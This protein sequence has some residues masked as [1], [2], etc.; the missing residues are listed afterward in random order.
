MKASFEKWER[1]LVHWL[2]FQE[3]GRDGNKTKS[4]LQSIL[5]DKNKTGGCCVL[6]AG[7]VNTE[8]VNYSDFMNILLTE[9]DHELYY[10]PYNA[11]LL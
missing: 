2:F 8:N 4:E 6:Y 11:H 1:S 5:E 7:A 9:F 3:L 10:H